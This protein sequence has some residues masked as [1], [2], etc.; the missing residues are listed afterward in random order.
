MVV[1]QS[2]PVGIAMPW[3]PPI[4]AYSDRLG[5]LRCVPCHDAN[6]RSSDF[7][8]DAW[9]S[10]VDGATCDSC[11]APILYSHSTEVLVHV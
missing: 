6:G 8:Y 7:A 5:Y 2:R 11:G 9:N 1:G 3:V 4:V 10:A